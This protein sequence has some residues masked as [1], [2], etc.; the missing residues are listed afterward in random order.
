MVLSIELPDAYPYV[1]LSAT[2]VPF[3]TNGFMMGQVMKARKRLEVKYPN[4]CT[5]PRSASQTRPKLVLRA[6]S[7]GHGRVSLSQ[8]QHPATTRTPMTSTACSAG[9]VQ[10]IFCRQHLLTAAANAL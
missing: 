5:P 10:D 8:T 6:L 1:I 4:L 7:K 9:D 2:A 3:L